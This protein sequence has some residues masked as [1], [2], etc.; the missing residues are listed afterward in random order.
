MKCNE[1][2]PINKEDRI[3]NGSA[4]AYSIK[5]I[6]KKIIVTTTNVII[7]HTNK[8]TKLKLGYFTLAH[9]RR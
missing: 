6:H 4:K 3:Y 8:P 7:K 9:A 5:Q 1:N 2:D